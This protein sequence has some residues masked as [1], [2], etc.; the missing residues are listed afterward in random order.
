MRALKNAAFTAG[1]FAMT[2]F[3]LPAI[4]NAATTAQSPQECLA[5]LN[6]HGYPTTQARIDACNSL[7]NAFCIEILEDSQVASE[8]ARAACDLRRD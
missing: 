3:T 5:Y 7:V 8:H 1:L 6:S 4:A 2:M